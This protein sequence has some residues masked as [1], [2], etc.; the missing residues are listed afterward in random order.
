MRG[1]D[2]DNDEDHNNQIELPYQKKVVI[3]HLNQNAEHMHI[4]F[5]H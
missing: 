4:S 5:S 1:N 2:D 3:F